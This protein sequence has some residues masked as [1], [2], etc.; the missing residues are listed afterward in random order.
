ML[1]GLPA[2][3]VPAEIADGIVMNREGI[4]VDEAFRRGAEKALEIARQEK[5]ELIITKSRSPS[6]GA[7]EIYDGTFTGK[8]IPAVGSS[9]K[10]L[11]RP[12]SP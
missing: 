8:R 6:C 2:P 4:R 10:W 3:R 12:V 1:G 5:P 7:R 9:R 11:S